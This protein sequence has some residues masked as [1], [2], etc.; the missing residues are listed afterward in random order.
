MRPRRVI[1]PV[2]AQ[3]LMELV[4]E[5]L[6]NNV[7]ARE[8]D[9]PV[10]TAMAWMRKY[11]AH[12]AIGLV[13][14]NQYRVYSFETKLAAVRF[15][16]SGEGSGP[17]ALVRFEIRNM[18]QLGNWVRL[19]RRGG[20]DALRPKPRGRPRSSDEPGRPETTSA[21][22]KRLEMENAALKKAA[23]LV[24]EARRDT[25]ISSWRR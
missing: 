24:A 3:R 16:T 14:V 19:Y 1:D 9:V 15:V 5:G 10:N 13:P 7:I 12:G 4:D 25:N 18:S 17:D 23:A 22:I 11:R 2:L 6:G 21:K 8:L 20:A